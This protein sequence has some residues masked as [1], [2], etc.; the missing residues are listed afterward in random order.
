[1]NWVEAPTKEH[2]YAQTKLALMYSAIEMLEHKSLESISVRE[3]CDS[4]HV[5]PGA[6]A[7]YFASKTDLLWY[8]MQLWSIEVAWYAERAAGDRSGLAVIEAIFDRIAHE[9]GE[10]P[11]LT[12]EIIALFA[13]RHESVASDL[14]ELSPAEGSLAFPGFEGVDKIPAKGI[15]SI[16]GQN[17][18]RALEGGELAPD[19]DLD[20]AR[21]ALT[22]IFFGVPMAVHGRE[23][24]GIGASYRQQLRLLWAGLRAIYPLPRSYHYG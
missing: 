19:T 7:S 23:T 24:Q 6:F 4:V 16:L 1:M 3:L 10:R 17:L 11:G 18:E 9:I 22:A 12:A 20:S 21:V 13:R 8:F 15:E 5:P 2:K 14:K